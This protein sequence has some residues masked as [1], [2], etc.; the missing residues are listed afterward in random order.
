MNNKKLNNQIFKIVL[1]VLLVGV[2]LSPSL[3]VFATE[4]SSLPETGQTWLAQKLETYGVPAAIATSIGIVI[5]MG[6]TW[7]ISKGIRKTA[8]VLT[9]V[10]SSGTSTLEVANNHAKKLV[11]SVNTFSNKTEVL[12]AS[13][14]SKVLKLGDNVD[15]LTDENRAMNKQI[16]IMQQERAEL[17]NAYKKII[18]TLTEGYQTVSDEPNNEA[19]AE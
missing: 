17:L 11:D 18:K 2:I 7:L 8:G 6:V 13:L 19:K 5:G 10:F 16:E 1:I 14:E 3:V 4:T 15:V 12:I 9:K